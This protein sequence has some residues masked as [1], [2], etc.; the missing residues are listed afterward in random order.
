MKKQSSY[1]WLRLG[2]ERYGRGDLVPRADERA[3]FGGGARWMA[4][5]MGQPLDDAGARRAARLA[6]LK[7]GAALTAALV[8]GALASR[9]HL[10]LGLVAFVIA[11]Y[12]VEVQGLF[13]LPLVVAGELSALSRS[14]RL[15]A[16]T[17]GTARAVI[18]ILPIA[19]WMIFAGVGRGFVRAWCEGCLAVI[20]WYE[21][22]ERA[23][24]LG[25]DAVFRQP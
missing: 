6:T 19:A 10:L 12:A 15:I 4:R 8:A 21:E 25:M 16:A 17:G 11:F 1:R 14:R 13:L 7:Y 9:L 20:A 2:I 3:G 5:A 24:A 22:A 18:A 23:R